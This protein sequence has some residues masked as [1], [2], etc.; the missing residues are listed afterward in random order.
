MDNCAL[1]EEAWSCQSIEAAVNSLHA[2]ER[3]GICLTAS[4]DF[5][6]GS[7][8]A[9]PMTGRTFRIEVFPSSSA[10]FCRAF[11]A[12][13]ARMGLDLRH[14]YGLTSSSMPSRLRFLRERMRPQSTRIAQAA[15][16]GR[17][18]MRE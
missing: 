7:S 4:C 1:T 9:I 11:E 5:L 3:S 8:Q 6:N 16:S 10:E 12:D 2:M 18:P 15:A 14:G 13:D 17:L